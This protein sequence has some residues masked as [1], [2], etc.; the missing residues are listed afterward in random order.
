MNL[1]SNESIQ[2]ESH[3]LFLLKHNN[4]HDQQAIGTPKLRSMAKIDKLFTY[5]HIT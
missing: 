2:L 4:R 3:F 1:Y 5:T